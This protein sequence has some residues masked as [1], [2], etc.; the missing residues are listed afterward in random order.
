VTI[1]SFDVNINNDNILEHNEN[2]TLVIVVDT[3]PTKVISGAQA[4]VVIVDDDS[5]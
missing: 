1:S 3:L 5:K 2:F 4:T